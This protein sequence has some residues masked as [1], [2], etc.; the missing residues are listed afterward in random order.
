MS[1]LQHDNAPFLIADCINNKGRSSAMIEE[2]QHSLPVAVINYCCLE[3]RR[4]RRKTMEMWRKRKRMTKMMP[5][6]SACVC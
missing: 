1:M 6:S 4:D 3:T 5:V 2:I